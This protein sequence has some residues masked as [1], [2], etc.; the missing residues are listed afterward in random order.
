[1][2]KNPLLHVHAPKPG[3]SEAEVWTAPQLGR[4]LAH[5]RE[6]HSDRAAFYYLA[7][8]TGMRRG[9]IAGLTW[10][11]IDLEE[12]T[13]TVDWTLGIHDAQPIWKPR[14]KSK[15]GERTMS[16]DPATVAVLRDHRR[17]RAAD[18]LAFGEAWDGTYTDALG[19]T[20]EGLVFTWA[21]GTVVN[22]E[23]WTVW[24]HELCKEAKLPHRSPH[25]L[26]HSYATIAASQAESFAD[27]IVL[28]RRLD[29]KTVAMT[30]DTYGHALPKQDVAMAKG[31]AELIVGA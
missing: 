23:R 20:R 13:V 22:P 3:K 5:V 15:A 9:E 18:R 17:R 31:I 11:D 30:L 7:S 19:T 27:V 16:L 1:M 8:T 25:E 6:Q 21:D 10:D 29:H 12:G 4:F 2:A 26:R 24:M 28:S 14:P